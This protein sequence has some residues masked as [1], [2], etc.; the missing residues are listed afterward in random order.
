MWPHFQENLKQKEASLSLEIPKTG[1]KTT[2]F[3]ESQKQ[4]NH[5]I[6]CRNGIKHS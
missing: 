5:I 4:S 1:R 2:N 6:F 3:I